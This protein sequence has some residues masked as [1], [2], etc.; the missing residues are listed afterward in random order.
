ME[1][2]RCC[3]SAG[4]CRAITKAM[5]VPAPGLILTT[6][7][8]DY[9]VG[10]TACNSNRERCTY[11]WAIPHRD[12]L[13]ETRRDVVVALDVVVLPKLP[14]PQAAISDV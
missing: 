6:A 10:N 11:T 1:V 13:Q 9:R 14:S 3:C 8:L 2:E 5:H 12:R 7:E 4:A